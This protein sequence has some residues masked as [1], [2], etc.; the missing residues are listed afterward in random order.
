MRKYW[1]GSGEAIVIARSIKL[2][3]AQR[4]RPQAVVRDAAGVSV[5]DAAY[6]ASP[7]LIGVYGKE[8]PVEWIADDLRYCGAAR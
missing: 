2:R 7:D 3:A 1:A 6:E 5:R 8:S 4:D